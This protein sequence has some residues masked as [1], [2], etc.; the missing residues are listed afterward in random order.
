[1]PAL[2]SISS[3]DMLDW[4]PVVAC[5]DLHSSGNSQQLGL[6][7]SFLG[8]I[9]PVHAQDEHIRSKAHKVTECSLQHFYSCNSST[10]SSSCYR[11]IATLSFTQ[12]RKI[13]LETFLE[14][15]RSS[16]LFLY[17]DH[18]SSEFY[19][20]TS[21]HFSHFACLP[22]YEGY[23]SQDTVFSLTFVKERIV[24]KIYVTLCQKVQDKIA[25]A[26]SSI[27]IHQI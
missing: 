21:S 11:T 19:L 17:P 18:N 25:E 24:S 16:Q 8:L 7:C 13:A 22:S 26:V 2:V 27:S 12:Q 4:F 3:A 5:T 23:N 10:I 9:S 6:F 20:I 15:C 14:G 1:M